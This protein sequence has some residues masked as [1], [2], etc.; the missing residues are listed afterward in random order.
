VALLR[1]QVPP[2]GLLTA[3]PGGVGWWVARTFSTTELGSVVVPAAGASGV[4][5][6]IG[7]V[8]ALDGR[9]A[10]VVTEE[11]SEL[12]RAAQDWAEAALGP[13]AASHVVWGEG[14]WSVDRSLD[15]ALVDA[16][17]PLVA[18]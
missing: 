3:D 7:A 6:A 4:A 8:A 17:G 10:T 12:H 18:F 2:G 13:S 16:A 9:T 5:A 14:D 11:R 15:A 1:E